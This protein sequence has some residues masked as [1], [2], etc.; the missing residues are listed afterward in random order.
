MIWRSIGL[1]A[2]ALTLSGCNMVL[3]EKPLFSKADTAQT[4]VFKAGL[5]AA[6][7]PDCKFDIGAPKYDWP[8]C[9]RG[10]VVPEGQGVMVGKDGAEILIAAGD[11][12]VI[13]IHLPFSP[14]KK[15]SKDIYLYGAVIPLERDDK[16]Q[17]VRVEAWPVECGPPPPKPVESGMPDPKA[18]VTRKPL[19]GLKLT[20]GNC[21]ATDPKVVRRAA[22]AT[23][24]WQEK[25]QQ[26]RWVRDGEK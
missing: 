13:Q 10:N 17:V 21:L 24:A 16:G 12:M 5:W 9:A 18:F 14:L 19:P 1:L 4:P 22:A 8:E 23:R 20:E 25:P 6:D 15:P 2:A 26:S 11:P 3:S 7:D